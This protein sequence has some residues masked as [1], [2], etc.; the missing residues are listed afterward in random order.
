M[1]LLALACTPTASDGGAA[2]TCGTWVDVEALE[3]AAGWIEDGDVAIDSFSVHHCG[4]LQVE[5]YWNGYAST[6]P[7]E[8][9]SA[10]KSYAGVL[11]GLLVGDGVV[12]LDQP[13]VELLPAYEELFVGEKAEITVRHLLTMTSGLSWQDFGT[14]NS[15]DR[16]RAAEDSVAFVLGEPLDASPGEVFHYNTGSS[17]LLS[18][19]VQAQTGDALAFA[20]SR[21]FGPLGID[22]W[23][24]PVLA[25]GVPQGGWGMELVPSDFAKLGQLLLDEGRWEGEQ[26]LPADFVEA[27]TSWQVET[28]YGGGYGFQLWVQTEWFEVDDIAAARGYGGQD[29]FVLEGQDAVVTFTG[30]IDYPDEMA[31]DVL[32]LMNEH[33]LPALSVP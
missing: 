8:L 2:A 32:E 22:D 5:G 6:T 29:C 11:T 33:V 15:F 24:W 9:Q 25:D 19:V 13:V 20:E 7:H 28:E 3:A 18:A 21:L 23:V 16:I 17:H 30:D 26:V 10:T 27:A 1:L 4:T 31:A 12:G 14:L